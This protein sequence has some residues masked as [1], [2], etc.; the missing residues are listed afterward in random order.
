MCE[1]GTNVGRYTAEA[2]NTQPGR[3]MPFVFW[4]VS[5]VTVSNFFVIQPQLW[6]INTMNGTNMYFNNIYVN[7]TAFEAPYGKN[8]VQ[9]TDG[10]DTMDVNNVHLEN[11]TYQGGD[12]CIAIKPRSY[13]VFVRN[14][15]C[16]GG[17]G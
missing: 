15:T 12:D 16:R 1:C 2:G 8:W 5:D 11:F 4:N 14:G 17:N 10:F 3:P 7:A 9:N 13:N 6:S